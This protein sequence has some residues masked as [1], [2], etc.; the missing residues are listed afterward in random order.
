MPF[1]VRLWQSCTCCKGSRVWWVRAASCEISLCIFSWPRT[2][3]LK[4][5]NLQLNSG[6]WHGIPKAVDL[7]RE[8]PQN[9]WAIVSW[10]KRSWRWS[11]RTY[12]RNLPYCIPEQRKFAP[13][14]IWN[15]TSRLELV[16]YS[17]Q[18]WKMPIERGLSDALRYLS[19]YFPA[20]LAL[21]EHA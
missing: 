16:Q 21:R 5:W 19:V 1:V 6:L 14:L 3:S 17:D 7:S 4:P 9:K 18:P 10:P 11:W 8:L 2:V 15:M 12:S 20:F 13:P